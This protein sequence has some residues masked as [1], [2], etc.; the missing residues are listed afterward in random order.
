ML[1]NWLLEVADTNRIHLNFWDQAMKEKLCYFTIKNKT[2][3][4]PQNTN[5]R[6]SRNV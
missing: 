2:T 4:H 1:Q 6:E 3:S 5:I